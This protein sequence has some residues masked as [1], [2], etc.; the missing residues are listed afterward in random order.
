MN[1]VDR[2]PFAAGL[3][4]LWVWGGLRELGAEMHTHG[5]WRLC[6]CKRAFHEEVPFE[7]DAPHA[8]NGRKYAR[9]REIDVRHVRLELDPDFTRRGLAGVATLNFTPIAKPL[10]RLRLDA[11]DLRVGKVEASVPV[12]AWD[13]DKTA[14]TVTFAKPLEPDVEA[15]VTVR[16]EA[17][18]RD[19][20]YFRTSAMGYPEGDD[21]FWTQGE[22]EKHRHWFPGYD[23]PNERFTSEV[24]C[25]V[26]AGMTVVSNGR[27][28]EERAEGNRTRF[29]WHQ[30]AEHVNYLISVVGGYFRRLEGKHGDLALAFLTPPS[31]FAVAENSFRDT[32]AILDFFEGEIGIDFPWAKYF[33]VCVT[34]FIAGGMENTSVTTLTTGTLFSAES[35]NLRTSH[36]L[37][38]HEAAHQW[39]GDLV[40]CKDWSHLWLN[41]GFATYYTHLYDGKK[42][43]EDEM[44]YQLFRDAEEILKGTDEKPIVWRGYADPMEQFDYRAYPKGA[45]VLHMI[46]SQ[47]GPDLFRKTIRTYLEKHRSG[48]VV[49]QDLADVLETVTGRSWDEFFD[50]WVFHGGQ[51]AL[52]VAYAWDQTKKQAK[53]TIEQTHK[54]SEAVLLFDF[55][56]P[57]RFVDQSGVAHEFT[58]RVHEV[59]EDFFFDL[60]SQ[61]VMV[62]IDPELAVLA[63]IAFTPADGLLFAQGED[64]SDAIGRLL[65][66]QAVAGRTDSR[67]LAFLQ[68]RASEDPFYGVRIEA[69]EALGKVPSPERMRALMESLVQPDDRVRQAAVRGLGRFYDEAAAARLKEIVAAERNPEIVA[70]ALKALGKFPGKE[71]DVLLRAGLQRSCH[72]ERIAV[73]AVEAMRQRGDAGSAVPLLSHLRAKAGAFSSA[74]LGRAWDSLAYLAREADEEVREEVR[75]H[76]ADQVDHPKESLRHHAIAALG[77]L[78]DRRSEGLLRGVAEAGEAGRPETKA[79]EEALKK[80]HAGRR[81]AEEVEALRKELLDLQR[82]LRGMK[83]G[84]EELRKK[85][86]P[87]T[88]GAK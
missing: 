22:P 42:S 8:G 69:I 3:V 62:R 55:P 10:R 79:A 50:Q 83:E 72:R 34:D 51:P 59:R 76:L 58:P 46:R 25:R 6:A 56:L 88:A 2:A 19:G 78:E 44:R 38:A 36:R 57:V 87:E 70:D 60:P 80:I 12:E 74:D 85:V 24:I 68:K 75:L 7:P 71:I 49:T 43:G 39:F 66:V 77:R 31:E 30:E 64:A 17:E 37:D 28:V 32:A 16:Y 35:G 11:V 52:R 41:E 48:A 4:F 18:P 29:H 5:G 9:D 47:I 82:E 1:K 73:A 23:Y 53:L 61:P 13:A 20:W 27:L 26:P 65:A 63:R 54:V 86:S 40:T 84:M 33:S 21:H 81:Q 15:W 67:S 45:W 14:L